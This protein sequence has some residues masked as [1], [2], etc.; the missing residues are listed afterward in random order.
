[1][2]DQHILNIAKTVFAPFFLAGNICL[3]GYIMTK[4][5]WFAG[6]GYMVIIFGAMSSLA[7]ILALL[8]YS[9]IN[10]DRLDI[11]LKAIGILLLN[12]P[13][14]VLYALIGINLL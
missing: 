11:C 12:I 10:W 7:V 13:I 6:S 1:M 8:V 9:F 4:N 2:K 14:A 3:F 5:E